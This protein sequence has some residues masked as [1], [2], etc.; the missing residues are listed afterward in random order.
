MTDSVLTGTVVKFDLDVDAP[1]IGTE[2]Y[3]G[4]LPPE[5]EALTGRIRKMYLNQTQGDTPVPMIKVLLE[6]I[7]GEYKGYTAWDNITLNNAAA[8]KWRPLVAVLGITA[9]DL[10]NATRVNPKD[11][12]EAGLR[13][14]GIGSVDTS[15]ENDGTP[16]YFGMYYDTYNGVR[17]AKVAAIKPRSVSN[18][19]KALDIFA[20]AT[21]AKAAV[22]KPEVKPENKT[23]DGSP[24]KDNKPS[25]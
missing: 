1:I 22:A 8:F 2:N 9:G 25:F 19:G 16:I 20:Q 15:N 11:V 23:K 6:C 4:K 17:S 18:N 10:V 5:R 7:E 3:I 14:V 21:A 12:T 24:V 13:I